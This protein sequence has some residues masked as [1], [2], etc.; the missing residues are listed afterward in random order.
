[1]AHTHI[2]IYINWKDDILTIASS[3]G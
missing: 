1:V 2:Y 3:V